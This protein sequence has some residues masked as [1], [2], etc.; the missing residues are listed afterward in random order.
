MRGA[1]LDGSRSQSSVG[2]GDFQQ[3]PRANEPFRID[4]ITL[5]TPV[6]RFSAFQHQRDRGE[7]TIRDP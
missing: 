1:K 2:S 7:K 4:L 6:G 5:C 3:L